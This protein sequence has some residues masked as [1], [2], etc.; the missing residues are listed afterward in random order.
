MAASSMLFE[1]LALVWGYGEWG[2]V[3]VRKEI[4]HINERSRMARTMTCYYTH[5]SSG[6]V[7]ISQDISSEFHIPSSRQLQ[8][9][10]VIFPSNDQ[11]TKRPSCRGLIGYCD[12]RE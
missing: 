6:L 10:L 8:A 5:Y 3:V 1:A 9:F 4:E 7:N 12:L 2:E 11:L